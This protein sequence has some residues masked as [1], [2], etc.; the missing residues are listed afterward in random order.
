VDGQLAAAAC[1]PRAQARI[2][3]AVDE[4]FSNIVNYAYAPG[5]GMATVRVRAGRTPPAVTIT[6]IDQGVNRNM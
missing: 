4:L 3:I 1:P 5:T 6:F 2:N